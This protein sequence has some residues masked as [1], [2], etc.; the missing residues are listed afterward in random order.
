MIVVLDA[1][2]NGVRINYIDVGSGAKPPVVLIHGFPFSLEMWNP[3][4][5]FLKTKNREI[6]YDKQCHWN[7]D[8]GDGQNTIEL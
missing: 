2:I 1:Q 3:Q 7:N 8:D 4:I 6:A 5:E